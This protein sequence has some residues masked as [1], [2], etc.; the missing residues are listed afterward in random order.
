MMAIGW[1][2]CLVLAGMALSVGCASTPAPSSAATAR[3][4]MVDWRTKVRAVIGDQDRAEQVIAQIDRMEH[5][6][7][8][9]DVE[10]RAHDDQLR[11]LNANFDATEADFRA[12]FDSFNAKKGARQRTAL[13]INRQIRSLVSPEEWKALSDVTLEALDAAL[14]V[15]RGM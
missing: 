13:A 6:I 11:S 9:A 15:G 7:A 12:A 4:A 1:K 5:L 10:R 3:Q 2:R 14:D 8:D